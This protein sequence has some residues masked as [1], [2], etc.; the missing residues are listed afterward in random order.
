KP[1]APATPEQ[2]PAARRAA[3][4]PAKPRLVALG[5][6]AWAAHQPRP[7]LAN[8]AA[9]GR[10]RGAQARAPWAGRGPAAARAL[11]PRARQAPSRAPAA[12][13]GPAAALAAQSRFS[14]AARVRQSM[15]SGSTRL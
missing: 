11:A 5:R 10:P 7:L 15:G 9:R 3:V 4:A 8:P 13:P 1:A 6:G 14:W 2:R 12:A